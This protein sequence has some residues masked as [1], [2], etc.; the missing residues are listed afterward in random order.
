MH[1]ISLSFSSSLYVQ[2]LPIFS[3][4]PRRCTLALTHR[5]QASLS[6]TLI[7]FQLL[8]ASKASFAV[9]H[10]QFFCFIL[11]TLHAWRCIPAPCLQ[12]PESLY[13]LIWPFLHPPVPVRRNPIRG[14]RKDFTPAFVPRPRKPKMSNHGHITILTTG[15]HSM[16]TGLIPFYSLLF[17]L[18]LPAPISTLALIPFNPLRRFISSSSPEVHLHRCGRCFRLD[19]FVEVAKVRGG[20]SRIT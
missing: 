7:V 16:S 8:L 13:N 2:V 17:Q 1:L 18:L 4:R 6:R 12:H 15:T 11:H 3:S 5:S 14:S 10:S 9:A 19:G 20:K